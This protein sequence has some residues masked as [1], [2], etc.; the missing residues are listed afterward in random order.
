M[1][2]EIE[3]KDFGTAELECVALVA[4]DPAAD[5]PEEIMFMPS[6]THKIHAGQGGKPV[7]ATVQITRETAATLQQSLDAHRIDGGK[8]WFDFDHERGPASGW[9]KEFLWRDTPKA[10]VYCKVDW[11][12][13]GAEA[14]S[15]K[16]YR[17][18]SPTFQVDDVR[19][20]PARV[21]GARANMGGLVN[22]P[23]FETILPLWA[24]RTEAAEQHK[25]NEQ[26]LAA[27]QA[28]LKTLEQE[29]AELKAK[30]ASSDQDAAIAAKQT[31][32]DELK[33][34]LK[35]AKDEI[36]A[37]R[38]ADAKAAVDAAVA[39]GALPPK[40]EALQAK[41]RGLIEANSENAELLA[42]L[43]GNPATQQITK[44]GAGG[45]T[46][47]KLTREDIARVCKAYIEAKT[48]IDKGL[49][50]REEI[51]ARLDKGEIIPFRDI[52][53]RLPLDAANTLGTLVGNIITQ[54][55]LALIYAKRPQIRGVTTDFS[56]QGARLNQTVYTRTV[57]I[58]TVQDF[59]LGAAQARAD[60]D[61]PVPLNLAKQVL[62]TLQANEYQA[63]ARDLVREQSEALAVGLGNYLVDTVAALITANFASNTVVATSAVDYPAIIKIT[64][65]LNK[66]GVPEP[67]TAWVNSDVAESMREDE[68]VMANFDRNNTSGYAHWTNIEGF[69]DIWEY[70]SLPD[71]A[72][73]LT[74]FFNHANALLI[75]ARVIL[76]PEQI[77]GAGYPGRLQTVTDPVT[78]LSVVS[79]QW[80]E[81]QSLAVNDRLIALFGC[82]RGNLT[83]GYRMLSA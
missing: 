79:N 36:T 46:E 11:S 21:T 74:G 67:R 55:T 63:T 81:Q 69:T 72:I 12:K 5:V 52:Q 83:C 30:K 58:P 42:K 61:Y 27:L 3:A 32:I 25:M 78:G 2:H 53:D 9:P 76:N 1:D 20:N 45:G 57:G 77:I 4:L 6:G 15:G 26:E 51:N 60:V 37:K 22:D 65:A 49:V 73:N 7:A 40:D 33:A 50:Y 62:Y 13:P 66:A 8:P 44:P 28:K 16:A 41:W 17:S 48:P 29:N 38:N 47:V 54:R 71:N 14:I 24:K 59:P 10:G 68:V 75:A 18:F 80:V 35:T 70:P 43:P 39:R 64:A 34:E 82:A 23:A 31:E 19:A 56:D